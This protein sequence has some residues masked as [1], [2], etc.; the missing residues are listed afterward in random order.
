LRE[1]AAAD[2]AAERK[3]HPF[4]LFIPNTIIIS[5]LTRLNSGVV[6]RPSSFAAPAARGDAV[7][8]RWCPAPY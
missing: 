5:F 8:A 4:H 6:R 7:G 2:I 3:V 1:S